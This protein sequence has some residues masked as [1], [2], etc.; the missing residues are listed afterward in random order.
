MSEL[1]LINDVTTLGLLAMVLILGYYTLNKL[2]R[3]LVEHL[4]RQEAQQE[5]M[6]ILLRECLGRSSP[7]KE[8]YSSDDA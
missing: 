2:F 7:I 5:E 6:V 1:P 4:T 3:I 8:S